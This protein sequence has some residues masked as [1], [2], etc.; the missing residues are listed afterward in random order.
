MLLPVRFLPSSLINGLFLLVVWIL[1]YIVW[2]PEVQASRRV[3][4]YSVS[5]LVLDQ[6]KAIRQQAAA[7]A[8][9]SVI[10]RVAGNTQV[11]NNPQIKQALGQASSYLLQYSYESTSQTITL[12]G[13][14]RPARRLLMQFSAA[15]I[16]DLFKTVQ[17]AIWPDIRPEVLLWVVADKQGRTLLDGQAEEVMLFKEAAVERGLPLSIPLLDLTDRQ[18]LSVR[19][20]WAL[21][22]STIRNASSRYDSEA[23]LAGRVIE[24]A[25]GLWRASFIF[26]HNDQHL[27]FNAS[28]I[29][30]QQVSRKIIGRVAD[31]LSS[32]DAM[33]VSKDGTTPLMTMTVDNISTFA[34]YMKLLTYLEALPAVASVAVR[35]VDGESIMLDLGYHGTLKKLLYTLDASN[36]LESVNT[37][38]LVEGTS[39]IY[40][41]R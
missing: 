3:D 8:L 38:V 22:E 4:I 36:V 14:V 37:Q 31:Y 32:F 17:L 26:L 18:E 6:S 35:R 23:V 40:R 21:D 7:T 2:V 13:D 25:S 16:Q 34:S 28:G 11:L 1:I 29:N 15:K 19:R 27:Y 39:V 10:I 9:S 30:Q 41:W 5:Q 12:A 24:N 33:V 20:L